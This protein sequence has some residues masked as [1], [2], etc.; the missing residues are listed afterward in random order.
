MKN[1]V[2]RYTFLY[3]NGLFD[4]IKAKATLLNDVLGLNPSADNVAPVATTETVRQA[5]MPK[6]VEDESPFI[7]D[8]DDDL[9]QFKALAQS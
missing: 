6:K 2:E 5:V 9:K 8:D 3:M 1:T 7:E 4:N